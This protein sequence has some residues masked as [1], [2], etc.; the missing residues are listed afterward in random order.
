MIVLASALIGGLALFD[1]T[2]ER[3][4]TG[5]FIKNLDGRTY[6]SFIPAMGQV[7]LP[8]IT[9]KPAAEFALNVDP[10]HSAE[11]WSLQGRPGSWTARSWDAGPPSDDDEIVNSD[12][13]EIGSYRFDYPAGIPT[14]DVGSWTGETNLLVPGESG[15]RIAITRI[16]VEPGA[17][18]RGRGIDAGATPPLG[19]VPKGGTRTISFAQTGELP[20]LYVLDGRADLTWRVR[21]FSASSGFREEIMDEVTTDVI[22]GKLDTDEWEVTMIGNDQSDP[23]D[24]GLLTRGI[25]SGSNHLE[26]HILSAESDFQEFPTRIPTDRLIPPQ[27]QV[28][29]GAS[30]SEE[31]F[32]AIYEIFPVRKRYELTRLPFTF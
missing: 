14:F 30:R 18:R 12:V 11:I 15:G 7:T 31:R 27:H 26:L 28:F 10:E 21:A 2:K 13:E 24:L 25:R 3:F 22:S 23:P 16:P 6:F 32:S 20:D 4:P 29:I 5:A 17:D 1:L 9:T 8:G 19:R